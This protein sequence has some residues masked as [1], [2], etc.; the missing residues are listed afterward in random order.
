M[1]LQE[2]GWDGM[3]GWMDAWMDGIGIDGGL[4]WRREYLRDTRNAGNLLTSWTP[5]SF[6][7]RTLLLGVSQSVNRFVGRLLS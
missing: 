7:R 5:L 4:L 2:M 1:D 6:S 3:D